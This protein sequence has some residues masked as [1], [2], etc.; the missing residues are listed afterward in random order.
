MSRFERI[1]AIATVV[2][3]LLAIVL[4]LGTSG[5]RVV[6]SWMLISALIYPLLVLIL[7]TVFL[8]KLPP[9]ASGLLAVVGAIILL[10]VLDQIDRGSWGYCSSS[11]R[12][13]SLPGCSPSACRTAS[14]AA[15]CAARSPVG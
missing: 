13:G 12:S 5:D 3:A 7:L 11:P 1:L 10:F 4:P 14:P 8:L 9:T 2:T 6:M 15:M